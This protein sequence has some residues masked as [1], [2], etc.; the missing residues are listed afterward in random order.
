[1]P[2]FRFSLKSLAALAAV[3]AV[4]ALAVTRVVDA[5][6]VID[7]TRGRSSVCAIHHEP[8]NKHLVTMIHG[9]PQLPVGPVEQGKEL[10]EGEEFEEVEEVARRLYFPNAQMPRRTGYCLPT[11]QEHARIYACPKCSEAY[12]R[13]LKQS[14]T[15]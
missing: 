11:S 14:A 13:W 4:A 2:R 9:M 10:A 15:P 1:M 12:Q 3:V 8:M 5:M 7:F 6:Y